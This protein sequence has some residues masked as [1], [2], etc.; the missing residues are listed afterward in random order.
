MNKI[1]KEGL[2][3]ILINDFK[4]IMKLFFGPFLIAFFI[5]KSENS[6]PLLAIYYFLI[7][8]FSSIFFIVVGRVINNNHKIS[9]FKFG[10]L[11]EC[12]YA[13][14]FVILREK[15]IEHILLMALIYALASATFFLPYNFLVGDKINKKNR[16]FFELI[17]ESSVA[18]IKIIVPILL[19]FTIT[20]TNYSSTTLIILILCIMQLLLTFNIKKVKEEKLDIY[21]PIIFFKD[22]VKDIEMRFVFL[23]EFLKGLTI[24]TGALLVII[25]V[26]VVNAFK[27]DLALGYV[28][29]FSYAVSLICVYFYNKY[30]KKDDDKVIIM[31]SVLPTILTLLIVIK[32]TSSLI[33]LYNLLYYSLITIL[34][35]CSN[36]RLWNKSES[37]EIDKRD[38]VEFWVIREIFL[39]IGRMTSYLL[40]FIISLFF[41][42]TVLEIYTVILALSM[43]FIGYTTLKIKKIN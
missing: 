26:Y 38:R 11:M 25:T 28:T 15:V 36:A 40:L 3:V 23:G 10:I 33:L 30:F 7:Y 29:S 9:M 41:S 32:P 35:I 18:I 17:K 43:I 4:E 24:N 34:F 16:K 2:S 6:V 1:S 5:Q 37:K 12:I 39:N 31:C 27:T 22:A 19:G 20:I 42:K 14:M 13:L 8:L 21:N